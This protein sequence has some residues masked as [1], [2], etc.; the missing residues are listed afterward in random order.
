M[1]RIFSLLVIAILLVSAG[2]LEAKRFQRRETAGL[3]AYPI[4][5]DGS[6]PK[7]I[8]KRSAAPSGRPGLVIN[9]GNSAKRTLLVKQ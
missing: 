4:L 2:V 7:I 1:S 6:E 3:A 5:Q 8:N 9:R